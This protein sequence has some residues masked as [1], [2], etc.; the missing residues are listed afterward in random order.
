MA[1]ACHQTEIQNVS[2][3]PLVLSMFRKGSIDQGESFTI[4]GT[5]GEWLAAN[6]P[7]IKARRMLDKFSELVDDDQLLVVSLP[8][9]PC[10]HPFSSSSVGG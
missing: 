9:A 6:H 2:G 7:G 5:P 8:S 4:S 10:G 3:G 1:Y